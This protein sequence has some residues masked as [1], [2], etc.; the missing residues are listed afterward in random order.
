MH[1]HTPDPASNPCAIEVL[2]DG[3]PVRLPTGGRSLNGIRSYLESLA[4]QHHRILYSLKVD[5]VAA[6]LRAS[7]W[8]LGSFGRVEAHTLHPQELPLHLVTTAL[9]QTARSREQIQAAIPLVLINE[10]AV[11]REVWWS[12]ANQ[13]REPLL[14]LSLF[15]DSP[16]G[17]SEQGLLPRRVRQWQF[18][19]LSIILRELDEACWAEN[20]LT[21]SQALEGRALPWVESLLAWL[22][23]LQETLIGAHG[24]AATA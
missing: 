17:P 8:R 3:R 1:T 16:S 9:E 2:L 23:L 21:L 11:A 10:G 13:L 18:E 5:G 20:P 15:P 24:L 12:L 7:N 19:Q 4:L 22:K 6:D 14:T